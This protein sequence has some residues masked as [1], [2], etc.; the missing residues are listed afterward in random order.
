LRSASARLD[1]AWRRHVPP[2]WLDGWAPV[3][4]ALRGAATEVVALGTGPPL[5]LLPPLPG[6]K[7]AWIACA[8]R[9]A[10]RF[11]VVSFDLR[12]G[13]AGW[14]ALLDD[15]DRVAEVF[16]EARAGVVGHSLGGALALRWALR[17]PERVVALVLSSAFARLS[18]PA[19]DRLGRFVEQPLVLA[20]QRWLPERAALALARRLAARGAWVYDPRC[21]DDVLR[22]VRFG[23][24]AVPITLAAARVRLALA[25]DA[26]AAL[27][28]VA[29]PTLVV[30]GEGESGFVRQAAATLLRGIRGATEAVSPGAGHLHPL[31]NAAWLCATLEEWLGSR[32]ESGPG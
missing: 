26:T 24:R 14:D 6:W 10:R 12:A 8:G 3:P 31:S 17:R 32:L 2:E 21:G 25:H 29:C 9:L 15:V 30:R 23:I 19:G 1:P 4:F 7:E 20:A 22:F 27:P 13:A 5:L 11:R 28:A 18:T 16:L